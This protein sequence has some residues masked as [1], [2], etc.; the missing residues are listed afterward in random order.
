MNWT[1]EELNS[2]FETEVEFRTELP[3]GNATEVP[4]RPM[5]EKPMATNVPMCPR[6]SCQCAKCAADAVETINKAAIPQE[7]VVLL[8]KSIVDQPGMG[9]HD[10]LSNIKNALMNL[11]L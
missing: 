7:K 1:P 6:C 2:Y 9:D 8:I 4:A 11:S 10:R 3:Q 5:D